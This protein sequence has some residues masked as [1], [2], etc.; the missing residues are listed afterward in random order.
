MQYYLAN[1]KGICEKC[2]SILMEF[3]FRFVNNGEIRKKEVC[4]LFLFQN[5]DQNAG[6]PGIS[7]EGIKQGYK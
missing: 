4:S 3:I 1:I 2:N 6:F 7:R 5:F